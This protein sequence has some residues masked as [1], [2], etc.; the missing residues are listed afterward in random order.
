MTRIG[1]IFLV[2]LMLL[3]NFGA[4]L[5]YHYCGGKVK[6]AVLSLGES[7]LSC[8]PESMDRVCSPVSQADGINRA[9]CCKNQH[10]FLENGEKVAQENHTLPKQVLAN[11]TPVFFLQ[12]RENIQE[13]QT[14]T[15]LDTSPIPIG[16]SFQI[17]YQIFLI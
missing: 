3:S 13:H 14:V 5:S 10:F 16:R 9:P 11:Y 1:S 12:V 8:A 17:C 15:F 7:N 6:E 4:V 2:L